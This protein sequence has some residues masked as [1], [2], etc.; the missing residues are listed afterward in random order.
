MF[1]HIGRDHAAIAALANIGKGRV[2]GIIA[3]DAQAGQCIRLAIGAVLGLARNGVIV[4][5]LARPIIE[6]FGRPGRAGQVG[7][8]REMLLDLITRECFRRI[9][10]LLVLGDQAAEF[11]ARLLF[12]EHQIP[13]FVGGFLKVVPEAV[14]RAFAIAQIAGKG[15]P[16]LRMQGGIMQAVGLLD[17]VFAIARIPG[18]GHFAKQ[19]CGGHCAF[20]MVV[21]LA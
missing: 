21:L 11:G 7:H 5:R 12:G 10:H 9:V 19:A 6:D 16:G 14:E 4:D 8:G 18:A 1:N 2:A 15:F 20:E 3:A 13:G 17:R